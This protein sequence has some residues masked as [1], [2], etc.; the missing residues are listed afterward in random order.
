M[1]VNTVF[2]SLFDYILVEIFE[3][4]LVNLEILETEN[5]KMIPH[6]ILSRDTYSMNILR[7]LEE[8]S[9]SSAVLIN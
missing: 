4:E 2:Q 3:L 7:V 9:S 1:S 5:L 8:S 6:V